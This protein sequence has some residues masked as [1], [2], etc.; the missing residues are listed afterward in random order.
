[1]TV[2]G[3]KLSRSRLE[4]LYRRRRSQLY[5]IALGIL[6]NPSEAEDAV[7]DAIKNIL[8]AEIEHIRNPKALLVYHP[9]NN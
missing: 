3:V 7:H 5:A 1:M 4:K 9:S 2:P 6:G 8:S